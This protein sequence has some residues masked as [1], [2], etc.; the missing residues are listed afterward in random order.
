[1]KKEDKSFWRSFVLALILGLFLGRGI[2]ATV[3]NNKI[4]NIKQ[5]LGS[6]IC[7]EEY[8]MDY[9][10]YIDGK[11]YCKQGT[12]TKVYDGIN[13]IKGDTDEKR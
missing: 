8:N 12:E 1:M 9:E 6:A 10:D 11:L 7:N 2:I 4:D 13:V 5:E 3:A